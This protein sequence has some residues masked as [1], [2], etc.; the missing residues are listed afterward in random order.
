[1]LPINRDGSLSTHRHIFCTGLATGL[2]KRKT[3]KYA[4][5]FSVLLGSGEIID[6][7]AQFW[8]LIEYA[9]VKA[10]GNKV[11]IPA[12]RSK[13]RK[14]SSRQAISVLLPAAI[15]AQVRSLATCPGR[16]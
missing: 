5:S 11:T 14:M 4:A 1:M 2:S 8:T 15:E 12:G 10:R 13:K 7:I 16:S 6:S 9:V 3:R